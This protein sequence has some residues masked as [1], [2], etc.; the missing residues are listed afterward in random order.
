[1]RGRFNQY[2]RALSFVHVGVVGS[3]SVATVT[4]RSDQATGQTCIAEKVS[5]ESVPWP[6]RDSSE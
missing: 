5:V 4:E 3:I 2:A 1:M 6:C